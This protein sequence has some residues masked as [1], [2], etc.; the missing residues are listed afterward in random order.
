MLSLGVVAAAALSLV[1]C[2]KEISNPDENPAVKGTPFEIIATSADTKTVNKD[3]A[4]EW[5]GGESINLFYAAAGETTYNNGGEFNTT[6]A[7]ASVKF[8]G[9]L[10]ASKLGDSNDWYAFYPYK[11]QIET[12]VNTSGY[13]YIGGR[14]D[15]PQQQSGISTAHL[16]GDNL[17][18]YAIASGVEKGTTPKL[19]FHHLAS[20]I[21]VHVTNSA[22][23][24]LNVNSVSF[25]APEDIV[26][27]FYIDFSTAT[28]IYT[29]ATY[30]S[31]T[32]NLSVKNAMIEANGTYDF[33]IVIKPFTAKAGDK[34]S[35]KVNSQTKEITLANDVTFTAGNIKPLNFNYEKQEVIDY[36][37]LPWTEDFSG[38]LSHYT[39]T[40]GGTTTKIY[41]ENSAG[42][43]V[44]ELL[45]SKGNGSFS[46][47]VKAEAGNYILQFK[48][49]YPERLDI[50][51]DVPEITVNKISDS[52]YNIIIPEIVDFFNITFKNINSSNN[53]RLD[54]IS[55]IRQLPQLET[56]EIKVN[57]NAN[58]PYT[59]DVDWL[60]VD[61]ATSYTVS[62][63]GQTDQIINPGVMAT[64]FSGLTDGD[65]VVTVTATAEGYKPA[66]ATAESIHIGLASRNLAFTDETKTIAF[67]ETYTNVLTGAKTDDVTYSITHA[68]GSAVTEDEIIIKE[69]TG[70]V[71][72]GDIAGE[73]K[74]TATAPATTEY[75]AGTASYTL[76]VKEASTL[77]DI[78]INLDFNNNIF[79]L[80]STSGNSATTETTFSYNGYDYVVKAADS[81]Y[82]FGSKATFIGKKDS[83]IVFPAI[84]NYRLKS[85]EVSNCTGASSKASCVI[86]P[87]T[88]TT[89]VI[90]GESST[91]SA[92]GSKTWTTTETV[93]N[94]AYRFYITNAYAVQMTKVVLIY[95]AN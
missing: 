79:K 73:Y 6:D 54:D 8:N 35:L 3:L 44:P 57:K 52:E 2:Q 19:D 43:I 76:I 93:V 82:Y 78:T 67:G 86:V 33:Y 34:L 1:S 53:V 88:S 18:M 22:S 90:G 62:C 72:A 56:P 69:N 51:V 39:L 84:E 70:E 58:D 80:S 61:N 89:P 9:T 87:T 50:S 25:T 29:T 64:S 13:A 23:G 37:T 30:T 36:V 66:T 77:E 49:N 27:Q 20:I 83:Y 60:D 40:N 42:G 15:T 4:T 17:P 24:P 94:T 59:I 21:K 31:K 41:Q 10:D 55:L 16:A 28:P 85:V 75:A 46:A 14:S 71:H 92:G 45:V 26:G 7:G 12:P 91:I 47:K 5:A 63:T 11:P 95:T 68:D 32:A 38:D 81:F 74:I 48:A 65:Y